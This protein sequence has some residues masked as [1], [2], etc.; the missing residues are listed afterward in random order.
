MEMSSVSTVNMDK[1]YKMPLGEI[2]AS[3]AQWSP[4]SFS[5]TWSAD[6]PGAAGDSSFPLPDSDL[7]CCVTFVTKV[8]QK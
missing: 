6:V 5:V 8:T 2:L 1:Y 4:L 3:L 7:F